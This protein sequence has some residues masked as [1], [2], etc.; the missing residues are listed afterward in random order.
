MGKSDPIIIPRAGRYLWF[1]LSS[2]HGHFGQSGH[3]AP[4]TVNFYSFFSCP[5]CPIVLARLHA[6]QRQMDFVLTTIDVT[7][8]PQVLATKKIR[9]VP[10]VE[11]GTT[12]WWAIPPP[13]SWPR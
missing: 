4:V 13:S 7:L 9:S 11:V 3:L 12:A 8:K 10:V 6:L 2:V 5:F 1:L